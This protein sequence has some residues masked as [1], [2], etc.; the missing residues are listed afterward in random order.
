[1]DSLISEFLHDEQSS[2]AHGW[3][4]GVGFLCSWTCFLQN[5]IFNH[6][7]IWH[8]YFFQRNPLNKFT[9]TNQKGKYDTSLRGGGEEVRGKLN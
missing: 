5:G 4:S 6:F 3:A 7:C 2:T 9:I 1:M 8:K